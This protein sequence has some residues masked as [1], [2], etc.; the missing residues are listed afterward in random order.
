MS[1]SPRRP[2]GAMIARMLAAHATRVAAS[3]NAEWTRAM[4]HEQAHLPADAS[5]LLWALGCV[6]VSYRGRLRAMTRVPD[7]PR[8]LLLAVLLLCLGP[9][10]AYFVFVAVSAAQGDPLIA[11]SPLTVIEEG[12]VFGSAALIGPVGLAAAFWALSSPTRGPGTKLMRVLWLLTLWAL[13]VHL[14]LLGLLVPVRPRGD[15][16]T[17]WLTLFIPFA[18]L[19]AMAVAQLQWLDTRRRRP[20]ALAG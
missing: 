2:L 14:G 3:D 18:L 13:A 20:L 6:L 1:L 10:C 19:P 8:W 17:V 5:A 7:L 9:A 12:L 15:W 16:L 4:V 11:M